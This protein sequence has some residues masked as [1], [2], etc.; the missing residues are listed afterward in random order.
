MNSVSSVSS[1]CKRV[2]VL[3]GL[4]AGLAIPVTASAHTI[5][6]C[7]QDNGGVTTFYAG[8]YH[9]P[10]E[11][12]SPVGGIIIDGF[13][14]PFSG[15]IYPASLPSNAGCFTHSSYQSGT[16]SGNPD[17]VPS[18]SVVHFQTFTAAFAPGSH[19]VSFTSSNVVQAPIGTF[20]NFTF[21]GAACAD[22]DF[23]TICDN[24]DICPL[25]AANDGDGD[26]FCANL[27]N[28]PLVYNPNQTDANGNGQGDV[29]EGVVCGNGLVQGAEQCD[30]GNIAG[31]D[32]CSAICTIEITYTPPTCTAAG[33]GTYNLTVGTPF[34]TG[35]TGANSQGGNV[36]MSL[37]SLPAAASISPTSGGEPL[38]STL[39][40]TPGSGDYGASYTGS[41]KVTNDNALT[42]TCPVVLNVAGNQPPIAQ[43]NGN[44]TAI[45]KTASITVS[46]V[47][48]SDPDGSISLIE[49]RCTPSSSF[50][51]AGSSPGNFACPAIPL[52]GTYTATVRVTDDQGLQSTDTATITVPN[53]G[54]NAEANGPYTV[55]QRAG[56]NTTAA[57]TISSAGSADTDGGAL[58]YG[59][60]CDTTGGAS[61]SS[62]GTT[63]SCFYPTVGSKT[64]SLRVCDP[65]GLCDTDSFTVNVTNTSPVAEA[66]G[67]Y[68]T[69]QGVAVTVNGSGSTDPDGV[70]TNYK[71]DCDLSNG[72]NFGAGSSSPTFSCSYPD[73]GTFTVTLRVTDDDNAT[74]D[75][76]A[77]V[78]VTNTAPIARAG[79]PYTGTKNQGLTVSGSTS[80]DSDGT[81]ASYQWDCN[82]ADSIPLS[83]PSSSPTFSCIYLAVG[84]YTAMLQVTDNDGATS[85]SNAVVTIV[86]TQPSAN[87]G[88]PYTAIQGVAM[89]VDGSASSDPDGALVSYEWDCDINSGPSY[90]TPAAAPTFLC[91]YAGTGTYTAR[92]RVTDDDGATDTATTTITVTNQVPVAEAGGP[93]TGGQG[94]A[95]P[96]FAFGSVDPDGSI[97]QYAW[98]CDNNGTYEVTTT[99]PT[100]TTCTF[101]TVGIYTVTLRV[102]DDDNATA[103]DTATVTIGNQTP[104]A[105]AGGPYAAGQTVAVTIDGSGSQDTDGTLVDYSW[106]CDAGDGLTMVSTGTTAAT[107]CTYGAVGTYVVTLTVTDD[108]GATNTDTTNVIV[109]NGAPVA[110]AGGP[111]TGNKGTS[112]LVDGTSSSDADGVIVNYAWD[113]DT[114]GTVDVSNGTGTATCIY[115]TV[116][117]YTIT[118]TV[119]DDDGG[120]STDTGTVNVPLVGPIAEAGGPY[121]GTQ[122]A[123]ITV[124]GSGSYD[125]DGAIVLWEWDCDGDNV[126]DVI[127]TTSSSA[128]CTFP[129]VTNY[130][131]RLR[132]TDDDGETDV[133]VALAIITNLMPVADAGGPYSG[134]EN[135]PVSVDGSGSA[136]LDGFLSTYGWD[137]DGD[138][139]PDVVSSS[140]T[141]STCTFAAT[142]TYTISLIVTDSDGDTD[143]D[144]ATVVISS[145]PPVADAGGPYTTTEGAA[146]A[147]D[148]T[149]SSDLGGAII[150]WEW[151][152]TSNGSYDVV[153]IAGLGSTC[154]YG[155]E[156][157]YT[158]TLRVTDDDGDTSVDVASVTVTNV[159]PALTGPLGPLVGLE[160]QQLNWSAASTDP[161]TSD[162][163]SYAWNFGDG[164]GDTGVSVSH[165]Y[166]NEGTYIVSVTVSDGDGGVDSNSITVVVSNVA[167]VLGL[168]TIPNSANEGQLLSFTTSAT[169]V[170]INDTLTYV[171][172]MGDG[173]TVAGSNVTY[174][175]P[176]N[177]VFTVTATVSD[178]FGA[179]DTSTSIINVQNVNPTIDSLLGSLSGSEG[180]LLSWS[181]TGSDVGLADVLTFSWNFGDGATD[182]GSQADH[183]YANEGQYVVTATVTDDDGGSTSQT[184]TVNVANV[185]PVITSVTGPT[186]DEGTPITVAVVASDAGIND[187]ISYSWDLGDG[188]FATGASVTHTYTDDAIYFV[189]VTAMDNAGATAV[190]TIEVL[191]TNVAPVI[192]SMIATPSANPEEGDEI[193][194]DATATDQGIDDIPNLVFTWDVGDGT[195][196]YTGA[197]IEHTYIDDGVYTVTVSVD[198][199]D[200]GVT[201]STLVITVDNVVP[202]IATSPTVNAVQDQLYNYSPT[203][204]DPGDEVFTWTLSASAPAGMTLDT[205]TGE[206]NWTP[207]Y[208]DYLTG[209]YSVVLTV[210]DGDGGQDQQAWTITV[211]STDSDGDG[212]PDDWENTYGFDP[213][214]PTDAGNDPD[215]DGLTNLNEFSL[216]QDPYEYDGPSAP[217]AISP[218]GGAE[219]TEVSPDLLVQNATDP[220]GEALAYDFEL[221]L[222]ENLTQFVT[223]GYG[224]IEDTSGQT[225]WK[226]DVQLVEDSEYWWIARANDPW[227]PGPWTDAES[228]ILNEFNDPPEVPNLV[229]P[230]DGQIVTTLEPTFQWEQTEDPNEDVVTYDVWVLE[231][232]GETEVTFVTGIADS[233]NTV[234]EWLIDVVLNDNSDYLWTAR[235]VD[236]EGLAGPW[237]E[238]EPFF[239]TSENEAPSTPTWIT[240]DDLSQVET[241]SPNLVATE[242]TDPENQE[243]S[244]RFEV[245]TTSSFDS[246]D[247][248]SNTVPETAIGTVW[249]DLDVDSRVLPE[250]TWIF[251]KVTAIDEDGFESAPALISF[252]VRG[253]NDAPG[254]PA[255]ISPEDGS[256]QD[257]E[258]VV[259]VVGLATDIE[260]DEVFYDF[261]LARDAGL[262]DIVFEAVGVVAG[263]GPLG[264]EDNSTVEV[265]F[266]LERDAE[267]FWSARAVDER[268]A[269]STYL[270]P[271]RFVTDGDPGAVQPEDPDGYT[272]GVGACS[273]CQGS[274]IGADAPATAWLLA[275][276]PAALLLRRR[277]D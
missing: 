225:S 121:A 209:S 189:T 9:S 59:W 170:G 34:S 176:D 44:Y 35:F 47:G 75:D 206:L 254:Q 67:N 22:A 43:A 123:A 135:T 5:Q 7:W 182:T 27:D 252:F 10:F 258:Y 37:Q 146:M 179:T 60:D 153:S 271:N 207:D 250:N 223:A 230:L 64:G 195:P 246:V 52:G 108:D 233:G 156:G 30:D 171:W 226:V 268:G 193:D 142:G 181:M 104:I 111:Y 116:G 70:I 217:V 148:G 84:T 173:N 99:S 28:C 235:A 269:A 1:R 211:F 167:P 237:A 65:E 21:G 188:F 160:G 25:D 257:S 215:G 240:P 273:S 117:T 165:T 238:L 115:A 166:V 114:D 100:G 15:W 46:S 68:T 261:V 277:R 40:W 221:Y 227:T 243:I 186:G 118:L 16:T 74:D 105:N 82:T 63:Q 192:T 150:Q 42:A 163:V 23:D 81:I 274:V 139:V 244:Y 198:D 180:Q 58:T 96:V 98:D 248:I 138:L 103:T 134:I 94:V 196:P 155:D 251:A 57:V 14:Y 77:L 51:S 204:Q 128:T 72:L 41:V 18:P 174:T 253:P 48:S 218:I 159:N 89:T 19:T 137:C 183:A 242:V 92:I 260:G 8:T 199:L 264:A 107:F 232:D 220:Q 31:G 45:S 110:V 32:G 247:Y 33:G 177:G 191:V 54:P 24:V 194:L 122:G 172:D 184:L 71:W 169:D 158:L 17:G 73:P 276:V 91:S 222:D 275:L 151:D 12:P 66:A 234:T 162:S 50:V 20:P 97:T 259:L 119:T 61:Y 62:G 145:S 175:Y 83:A 262:S 147:L 213:L 140:P 132:V 109:S 216:G 267:Y 154:T 203:V 270:T 49:W 210:D 86:N 265:P 90:S 228:F 201:T 56:A 214:D 130:T 93:Y 205:S 36:A 197:G 208:D 249:W 95:V 120:T 256:S 266:D 190:A 149:A 200:G 229:Y 78:T 112:I 129:L 136:D 85:T 131:V 80:T 76:T 126:Y 144:S 168:T 263:A 2:L 29:C 11:A 161:G 124:N 157:N 102:T 141:G 106:D 6:M 245:D 202:V 224:V 69:N 4:V 26:G 255:L 272:A 239:V 3:L 187:T 87:A 219:I 79:G 164:S 38:T 143:I 53:T 113:C 13:T 241:Q 178:D 152:C 231:A 39:S 127:S 133:D 55:N 125:T 236:D 101:A 212:M 88:G 185:A